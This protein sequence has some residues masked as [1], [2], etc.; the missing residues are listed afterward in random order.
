VLQAKQTLATDFWMGWIAPTPAKQKVHELAQLVEATLEDEAID[1]NA[2]RTYMAQA[3][4]SGY[5]AGL[6]QGT[7]A[8]LFQGMQAQDIERVTRSFALENCIP[9]AALVEIV[10]H[11]LQE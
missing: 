3:A 5:T 2:N 8:R 10:K 11:R 9:H 7:Y 1:T 6:M 4:L